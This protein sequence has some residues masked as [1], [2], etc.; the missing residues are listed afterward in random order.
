MKI[1]RK[2]S[3]L[4]LI[5]FI[6]S[7]S[8]GQ[9]KDKKLRVFVIGNSF[10]NNATTFLP[11][12]AAAHG[13]TLEMGRAELGGCSLQ[14]HWEIVE[15]YEANPNDPK[16]KRYNGK[17]LKM[18]FTEGKWDVVTIQQYSFLSSDVSSYRPYAKKLVEYIRAIQPGVKIV[19]HQTWA[20]R[21]DAKLFGKVNKNN[22]AK[23]AKE[24]WEKSRESYHTIAAEVGADG[25]IPTGNAFWDISSDEKWKFKK[26]TSIDTSTFINPQVI[27]ELNTLHVGYR[28]F[29]GEVA[30]DYRHASNA[31][32]YLAGLV[33]FGYLFGIDPQ[34]VVFQPAQMSEDFA[35]RLKLAAAIALKQNDLQKKMMLFIQYWFEKTVRQTAFF[36]L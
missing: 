14:T 33:W 25:I 9:S 36:K 21:S 12:M 10:S 22:N 6:A 18:M 26:D 29:K 13:V 7:L 5:C 34:K 15:A 19:L 23:T 4:L 11:Q 35:R 31:G 8:F 28:W 16:G 3:C 30:T 32:C 17:S 27:N 1:F 20:Y 2:L 24:M